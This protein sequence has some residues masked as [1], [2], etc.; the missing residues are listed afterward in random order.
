MT[1]QRGQGKLLKECQ[2][3]ADMLD[4]NPIAHKGDWHEIKT[5]RRTIRGRKV[6]INGRI[7][8]EFA[9]P[10]LGDQS[11]ILT[12]FLDSNRNKIKDTFQEMLN[13]TLCVAPSDRL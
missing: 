10:G 9:C 12:V 8:Y 7:G 2:Y 3:A 13:S 11:I 6:Q 5:S 4:D 1:N